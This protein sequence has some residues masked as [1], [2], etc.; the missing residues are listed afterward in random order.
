MLL[1][2]SG[3][4]EEATR[5]GLLR[6]AIGGLGFLPAPIARRLV[7]IPRDEVTASTIFFTRAFGIRNMVMGL[8]TLAQR[9][10]ER[11]RRRDW[12][13]VNAAVDAVDLGLLLMLALS[14]KR[15]RAFPGIGFAL[16]GSALLAWLDLIEELDRAA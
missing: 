6:I 9:D 10:A 13:R 4:R 15:T 12:Y 11:A 1:G 5:I 3:E 14:G 8:W 16:G 7:L 2:T